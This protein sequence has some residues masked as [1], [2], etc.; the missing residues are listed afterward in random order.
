[1]T[2]EGTLSTAGTAGIG[3]T[4]NFLGLPVGQGEVFVAA[5]D[6]KGL[7]N[8]SLC[9]EINVAIGPLELGWLRAA[10][11]CDE[12]V[13]SVINVFGQLILSLSADTLNNL[14]S[15]VAPQ[16]AGSTPQ[17]LAAR[18][19]AVEKVAFM[20]ELLQLPP[21]SLPPD[22]PQRLINALGASFDVIDPRVLLCGEVRPKLFGLPLAP[23]LLGASAQVY[24]GGR[25]VALKFSP[26]F[27]LSLII[28]PRVMPP[29]DTAVLA[30]SEVWPD[31][32]KALLAGL[33]GSLTPASA[34]QFLEANFQNIL[35]NS[36]YTINY[37]LAPMGIRLSRAAARVLN[38]N[39]LH[40]PV[41]RVPA[42]KRPEDRGLPSRP[43]LLLAAVRANLLGN[44][45]WKGN[46]NDLFTAFPDDTTRNQAK[47]LSFIEDYFPHGGFIGAGYLQFPRALYDAP[48]SLFQSM[49]DPNGDPKQRL[50]SAFTFVTRYLLSNVVAGQL[51]FYVPAPNPPA[52]VDAAGHP[53]M[54]SQLMQGIMKFDTRNLHVPA[55]Y[56]MDQS[57]LAGQVTGKLL[58]IPLGQAR[59]VGLPADASA[60]RS[61]AIF[62]ITASG[63]T[64]N[65][66]RDFVPD[67]NLI[68]E[69][70]QPP[71]QPVD[72]WASNKLQNLTALLQSNPSSPVALGAVQ[73]F[74]SELE[75]NVPKTK[76]EANVNL[77]VPSWLASLVQV[78][79]NA[80]ARLVAYSPQYD[81]AAIG[82]GPLATARRTG[83][84]AVQASLKFGQYFSVPNA[85]LSVLPRDNA[86][87]IL[88][89]HFGPTSATL[90][91][92]LAMHNVTLDFDSSV[93][94]L[95]AAG[96]L[97]PIQLSQVFQIV[98]LAG[99]DI[100]VQLQLSN[101][102]PESFKIGPARLA[103]NAVFAGSPSVRVHGN[104]T[105]DPFTYSSSGP[106]SAN[107]TFEGDDPVNL[108]AGGQTVLQITRT[109][110]RSAG[111]SRDGQGV[112]RLRLTL[113]GGTAYTAFPGQAVQ[114]TFTLGTDTDLM[115]GTDGKFS[116]DAAI[117][118]QQAGG[119]GVGGRVQLTNDPDVSLTLGGSVTLPA[120]N[121]Y[122]ILPKA[123][124]A[125]LAG[126][127][128]VRRNNGQLESVLQL[129]PARFVLTSLMEAS[130]GF[131]IDGGSDTTDFTFSTSGPWSA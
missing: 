115:I 83:G 74:L 80:G 129:K 9:G 43:D 99:N 18:L 46:S 27:L 19:S 116:L 118:N 25:D 126:S 13:T 101:G 75:T 89:G 108:V 31:P 122:A 24:K 104:A 55:L 106:W 125:M 124:G 56:S 130:Q 61:E 131:L 88:S 60:G 78:D 111:V 77:Q 53:L 92:G 66:L 22:L 42:W 4:V 79:G 45:L 120:L 6:S 38:P 49:L 96:V 82:G 91:G 73:T 127:V 21:S 68:F 57:F 97:G 94:S 47:G 40:H 28:D 105:A 5:T 81:P 52:F 15:R 76:L 70:R 84:I 112:T 59:I 7:P 32:A 1:V 119:A 113:A 93:P 11:K 44:P 72:Q 87:P 2:G 58:N 123:G 109:S 67:A 98:P 65:W 34:P 71:P 85:E 41:T 10:M 29:V 64:T 12:C 3:G 86:P 69:M 48:V 114:Q 16:F 51:S 37:E 102:L 117:V 121:G 128:M 23:D 54:P 103:F 62:Q 95:T 8:P 20:A 90:P 107:L 33:S 63:P 39:L 36:S 30:Y 26:S 35:E 50:Q 14:V 100:P 17:Q 110:L